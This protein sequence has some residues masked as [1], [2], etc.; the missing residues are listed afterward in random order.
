[1]S[2]Q[3][4]RGYQ[5]GLHG[6]TGYFRLLKVTMGYYKQTYQADKRLQIK[7]FYSADILHYSLVQ[8]IQH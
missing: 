5:R 1:M 8:K 6:T 2:L 3:I 4:T 7:Q